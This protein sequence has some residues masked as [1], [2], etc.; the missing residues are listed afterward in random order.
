M[1]LK[2]FYEYSELDS[3]HEFY[4]CASDPWVWFYLGKFFEKEKALTK[5]CELYPFLK[6]DNITTHSFDYLDSEYAAKKLF[7][8]MKSILN[9]NHHEADVRYQKVKN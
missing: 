4:V 1:N 3:Q 9:I 7:K 8:I 2:F 5:N 6:R